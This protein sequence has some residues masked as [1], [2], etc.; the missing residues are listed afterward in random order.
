MKPS[1]SFHEIRGIEFSEPIAG[2]CV[3][4]DQQIGCTLQLEALNFFYNI[5][6]AS[7]P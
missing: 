7:P 5:S 1:L 2:H 3:I 6:E 4:V